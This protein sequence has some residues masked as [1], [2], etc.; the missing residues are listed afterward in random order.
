MKRLL[1]R[2]IRNDDGAIAPTVALTVVALIAAGGIAFD[3]A[4]VASMDSEL[5]NAADQSALAA[6]SQLDGQSGACARA[7]AAANALLRNNTFFANDGAGT[8]VVVPTASATDCNGNASIKFYKS[9][10]QD[11]DTFGELATLDG[12]AHVVWI[13]ITPRQSRYALTPIVAAIRS[14]NIGAEAI[15][16]LGSAICKTPPVMLCNPEEPAGNDDLYLP[17]NPTRG[18]GLR[19]ITGDADAP[20]NFGWLTAYDAAGN[21]I[22]GANA[23]KELIAYNV[24]QA[25]CQPADFVTTKPGMSASVLDAVNGRFDVYAAGASSCPGGGTCSPA[26]NTR[27]DLVCEP[28][29]SVTACKKSEGD[30]K[31]P[32]NPYHPTS[33]TALATDGTQDMG[34]KTMGYPKDLC[35]AVKK[36]S[37][38]C[39]ISGDG[40]WDRDAY[41]R[42]NYKWDHA[43]WTGKPGLNA[44]VSRF[45]VYRWE[46]NNPS[47]GT[48]PNAAGIAI[49]IPAA[50]KEEAFSQAATGRSSIAT[51]DRR[52]IA[53]AVLNCHA[54]D[55]KGKETGPVATWLDSFLVEPA[56]QRGPNKPAEIFT[57]QKEVY[58]EVIGATTVGS[59]NSPIVRR[60]V[61]YLIR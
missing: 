15:A 37:N 5:Q 19:L 47:F 38:T 45:D 23:L 25:K 14:G 20:G 17:Y 24:P 43:T 26:E 27:K 18:I 8:A 57:D 59:Q 44:N 58:V 12:D 31:E 2:L 35:H 48:S 1:G 39:G 61:P 36:A 41:F 30:W 55:A 6:A 7:A 46:I 32:T 3:Y 21:L 60:D 28:N 49:P 11:T 13:A 22:E 33:T 16:S 29:A 53:I 56:M 4:R 34:M 51:P 52:R 9:Y 40:N 54:L 42:V 50:P 10:D